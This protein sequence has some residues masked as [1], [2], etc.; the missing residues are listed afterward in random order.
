MKWGVTKVTNT[1]NEKF[2]K[3]LLLCSDIIMIIIIASL[4]VQV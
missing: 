2:K 3:Q 1:V 4:K